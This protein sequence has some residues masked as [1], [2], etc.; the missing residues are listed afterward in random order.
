M[1]EKKYN[2]TLS[3]TELANKRLKSMLVVLVSQKIKMQKNNEYYK[4]SKAEYEIIRRTWSFTPVEKYAPDPRER[5][6]GE[7]G[8]YN[9]KRVVVT[10]K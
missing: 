3:E 7:V 8:K 6:K 5:H 9:G 2:L 10:N 4:I 1:N